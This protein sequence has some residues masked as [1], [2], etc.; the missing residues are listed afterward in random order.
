MSKPAEKIWDRERQRHNQKLARAAL[1]LGTSLHD[2]VVP[3][4]RAVCL[5]EAVLEA[6][7]R[8]CLEGNNQ[9]QAE[10]LAQALTSCRSRRPIR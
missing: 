8:E 4:D 2:K 5:L 6:G 3:A 10:F 9:T 7:D 1:V